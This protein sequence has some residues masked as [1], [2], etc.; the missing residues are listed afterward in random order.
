MA[1]QSRGEE[2]KR[3]RLLW[4]FIA[5]MSSP[6]CDSA[7]RRR[8]GDVAVETKAKRSSC[9]GAHRDH[10]GRLGE[11]GDVLDRRDHGEVD[12]GGAPAGSKE[13]GV[14]RWR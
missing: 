2:W 3:R 5:G 14:A 13:D 6:G 10:V 1:E 4:L 8:H 12:D 7:R 11:G 9:S